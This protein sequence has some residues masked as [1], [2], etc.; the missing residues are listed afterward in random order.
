MDLS[1]RR[2]RC[3]IGSEAAKEIPGLLMGRCSAPLRDLAAAELDEMLRQA[4]TVR[5][6]AKATQLRARARQVGWEQTLWEGLFRALGY[7]HNAWP[8]HVLAE[9]RQVWS[10]VGTE[11]LNL[12]ARVLGLSGLLPTEP[13][14]ARSSADSYLRRIWDLWWRE[15]DG[16]AALMLPRNVWRLHGLRPAG[17]DP[18]QRWRR[19]VGRALSKI[20][21]RSASVPGKRYPGGNVRL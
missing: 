17:S 12:Q 16:F 1:S 10:A 8:M 20:A 13:G 3:W 6:Q 4:A 7:K 19:R 14:R 2:F 21:P 11:V 5:L 18:L 9:S 15:R